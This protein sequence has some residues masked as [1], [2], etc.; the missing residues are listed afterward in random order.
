LSDESLSIGAD[1]VA[2]IGPRI[3]AA[4]AADFARWVIDP[5][6]ERFPVYEAGFRQSSDPETLTARLFGVLET[7]VEDLSIPLVADLAAGD[8]PGVG[9]FVV[10]GPSS[11][12][13]WMQ[14]VEVARQ[15]YPDLQPTVERLG[16]APAQ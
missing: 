1:L 10:V 5:P 13:A 8:A 2:R 16:R 12:D 4:A 14:G 3:P 7:I 6:V 15:V 11:D 9:R